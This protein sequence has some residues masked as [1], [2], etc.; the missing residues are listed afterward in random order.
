M[1]DVG[2]VIQGKRAQYRLKAILGEGLTARVFL[3]DV[4][5]ADSI[6]GSEVAVKALRP[7]LDSEI[8]ER[9]RDEYSNLTA[10][11]GAFD[12]LRS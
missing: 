12:R 7:G 4:V 5:P 1:T 2:S 8:K 10:I 3:A 9:F 6:M 11:L